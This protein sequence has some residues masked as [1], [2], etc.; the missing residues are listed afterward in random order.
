MSAEV[1]P[2]GSAIWLGDIVRAV[3]HLRP[4]DET[5]D[6]VLD[7]LL[8]VTEPEPP[9]WPTAVPRAPA[10]GPAPAPGRTGT[11][12]PARARP[13]TARDLV[14]PLRAPEPLPD[15]PEAP[16]RTD[17]P[18]M[19]AAAPRPLP[20]L[21]E[22]LD[23][24]A[25]PLA[26][27][28]PTLLPPGRDRTILTALCSGPATAEDIDVDAVVDLIA[29]GEPIRVLPREIVSS[30]R[31]GLQVLVDL[32]DGMTPFLGDTQQVLDAIARMAGP[33]GLDVLR[34]AVS[35]LHDPGA[36]AGPI[37]TWRPYRPP[38]AAQPILVLSDLGAWAPASDRAEVEA[39]WV[40][41]ATE[42]RGAGCPMVA[43]APV[44][45]DRFGRRLHAALPIVS[46]DRSTN[47]RQ[48][49]A[50]ARRATGRIMGAVR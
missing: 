24:P 36:G 45:A 12:T 8:G 22:V 5:M 48:A 49:V 1:S 50:A 29:R 13:P 2:M 34:F 30:T 23:E 15:E 21:E 32:G 35:P 39:S 6:T 43:L 41:V 33:D 3:H 47:V 4:D 9:A 46:W 11:P 10:P 44:P 7:L 17:L 26:S 31:R 16:T 38:T 20:T 18:P 14:P 37:W 40:R 42:A 27:Q 19:H 25:A 28:P